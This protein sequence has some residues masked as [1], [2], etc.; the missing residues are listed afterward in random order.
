MKRS[1]LI[2]A[3]FFLLGTI[4]TGAA[5]A[6][7]AEPPSGYPVSAERRSIPC[8]SLPRGMSSDFWGAIGTYL[9][10][11]DTPSGYV[12]SATSLVEKVISGKLPA[13][14]S[15]LAK[16][17]KASLLN[18]YYRVFCFNKRY[19]QEREAS[20]FYL[21]TPLMLASL[22]GDLP[23]ARY[24]V[25]SGADVNARHDP[26]HHTA[27]ECAA[28]SPS[29][30]V[31]RFLVEQG[32]DRSSISQALIVAAHNGKGDLCAYLLDHGADVNVRNGYIAA[33]PDLQTPLLCAVAKSNLEMVNLLISRGADVN[34][35]SRL[36]A[37]YFS[38]V[39]SLGYV[40]RDDKQN[41]Y[42]LPSLLASLTGS[43][44]GGNDAFYA[45]YQTGKMETEA[46]SPLTSTINNYFRGRYGGNWE[47]DTTSRFPAGEKARA[48]RDA[49]IEALLKAGANTDP[50]NES[51][52][53][54]MLALREGNEALVKRLLAAG[55]ALDAVSAKG[56]T[57]YGALLYYLNHE[58][59]SGNMTLKDTRTIPILGTVLSTANSSEG[60]KA[61][62]DQL[63][64][65]LVDYAKNEHQY[66]HKTRSFLLALVELEDWAG[67]QRPSSEIP[68]NQ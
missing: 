9:V 1:I 24:L 30:E 62:I 28:D 27:L 56:Q 36:D 39:A 40:I 26:F 64:E 50:G 46:E 45:L 10:K 43:M 41:T 44:E 12:V 54:L 63:E 35:R 38:K 55:A 3:F 17:D 65:T 29:D 51:N 4:A 7:T 21:Y 68:Q 66:I 52:T 57:A 59:S 48:A 67:D 49:I 8:S 6:Q 32:A 53:A 58:V 47:N 25:E 11:G 14:K 34:Q 5:S 61:I 16:G 13:V 2:S 22:R 20:P 31:A 19:P 37:E 42:S 23:M 60:R 15:A 18:C 33:A